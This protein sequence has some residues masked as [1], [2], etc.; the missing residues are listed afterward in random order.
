MISF[1][2]VNIVI[3]G[4]GAS[5]ALTPGLAVADELRGLLANS[6]LTLAGS[7]SV[8][9]YRRVAR[10][11]H[12]YRVVGLPGDTA[13]KPG[14]LSR[15]SRFAAE[16][17][18]LKQAGASAVVSV[19]GEIGERVGR[20]AV[21]LGLPLVVLDC[22]AIPCRATRYLA[23]HADL[24]CLGYEEA[25]QY[26]RS[27]GGPVRVTG[28]PLPASNRLS[29]ADRF[30]RRDARKTKPFKRLLILS[31]RQGNHQLDAVLPRAL[32]RLQNRLDSWRVVHHTNA[33]EVRTVKGLYRRFRI[34]AVATS[35]I[36]HLPAM[37]DRV[38]LAIADASSD[39]FADVTAAGLPVVL[40]SADRRS[41]G[42]Q[43]AN[44][45]MLQRH[46]ACALVERTDREEEWMRV[47]D[48]L[49]AD[50]GRRQLLS[51]ALER[52][53]PSDAA[54]QIAVMIRDLLATP[55]RR[56]SA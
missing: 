17:R 45:K 25:R 31:D 11:G 23:S 21:A 5:G 54:W 3:A 55:Q 53:F 14:L 19:G 13:R 18:L 12:K 10:G 44:A 24:V 30:R 27:P 26:I 2:T 22:D 49:L 43:L 40:A 37:L 46:G 8:R 41:G 36:H 33:M 32:D 48:P 52:H 20:A 56:R 15:L 4:G 42:Q 50:A 9:E 6:R 51:T 28:V 35:H 47:L 7:G 34:D 38:D 29:Y 39:T 1:G 16:R